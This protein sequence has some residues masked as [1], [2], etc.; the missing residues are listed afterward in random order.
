MEPDMPSISRRLKD[1][2]IHTFFSNRFYKTVIGP[3]DSIRFPRVPVED[4]KS[5]RKQNPVPYNKIAQVAD[6]SNGEWKKTQGSMGDPFVMNEESFHRKLW[7]YIHIVHV[8]KNAGYLYSQN[9][10][11]AIGAGREYILYFLAHKVNKIIGI[12]IYEGEFLGGEDERDIPLRPEKFAPFLYPRENLDLIRMD[13]R[14][15]EFENNSFDFVFSVSSIEHFGSKREIQKSINEMYR[16]LKPGGICVITTELKLNRLGVNIPNTKIFNLEK[17]LDMFKSCGFDMMGEKPVVEI[18]QESLENWVKL[19]EEI[20]K[21]PHVIMR[22]FKTIFTSVLLAFTKPGDTVPRGDWKGD[23][24]ILPLDYGGQLTVKSV[25][26]RLKSGDLFSCRIGLKNTG[27]FDWFTDGG[28]HRIAIG[29]KL[30]DREG[31]ML[32]EGFGDIVIPE[33]IPARKELSFSASLPVNTP[34]GKYRLFFGLKRE[35]I[36]WFPENTSAQVTLDIEVR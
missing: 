26:P 3:F 24:K 34:P 7:E 17:L 31:N 5:L 8:L 9:R 30:L 21:R 13:S 25:N 15:L 36:T 27:N 23:T 6:L 1:R 11:L 32:D 29:T 20:H 35:L 22:S 4:I 16:I 19:P 28:S 14:Q 12:D 18:E 33:N 2:F 10:G